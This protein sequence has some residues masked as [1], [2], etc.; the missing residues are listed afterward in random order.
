[1]LAE[2]R[3]RFADRQESTLTSHN[4]AKTVPSVVRA[5]LALATIVRRLPIL[6]KQ[7][8]LK[9]LFVLAHAFVNA[10]P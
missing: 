8:P 7:P 10:T 3:V 1:M 6:K 4:Q 2:R 5:L 9:R